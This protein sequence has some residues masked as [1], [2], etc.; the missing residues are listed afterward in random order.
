[1]KEDIRN[2]IAETSFTEPGKIK[3]ETMLFEEGIFDSMGLL[4][5]VSFLEENFGVQTDDIDLMEDNFKNINAIE[6]YVN[7]KKNYSLT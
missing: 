5:L 4:S 1:M 3:D 7:K 2:F 6:S